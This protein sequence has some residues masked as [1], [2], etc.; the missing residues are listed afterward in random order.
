MIGL[1]STC[2]YILS[3][4]V[5]EVGGGIVVF[6]YRGVVVTVAVGAGFVALSETAVR[7]KLGLVSAYFLDIVCLTIIALTLGD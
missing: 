5:T 6:S 7:H 2:S 1:N 3:P 4:S